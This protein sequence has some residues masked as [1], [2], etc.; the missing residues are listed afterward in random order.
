MKENNMQKRRRFWGSDAEKMHFGA[1]YIPGR[2][3]T[4]LVRGSNLLW[5]SLASTADFHMK[6]TNGLAVVIC[7]GILI[8]ILMVLCLEEHTK[9]LKYD[10]QRHKFTKFSKANSY[11]SSKNWL[12]VGS[13]AVNSAPEYRFMTKDQT[14]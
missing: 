6:S 14:T 13:A 2:G 10:Q 4:S 9:E 1:F 7:I 8:C 3:P 5:S 11:V 12:K